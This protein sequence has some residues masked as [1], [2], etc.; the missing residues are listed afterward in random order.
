MRENAKKFFTATYDFAV[1]LSK[2]DLF[3][4]VASGSA[5]AYYI[6]TGTLPYLGNIAAF[7]LGSLSG[8]VVGLGSVYCADKDALNLS[9]ELKQQLNST[10]QRYEEKKEVYSSLKGKK[11]AL[12]LQQINNN[13]QDKLVGLFQLALERQLEEKNMQKVDFAQVGRR[14][15]SAEFS[16]S[17]SCWTGTIRPREPEEKLPSVLGLLEDKASNA[18]EKS[19]FRRQMIKF[20]KDASRYQYAAMLSNAAIVFYYVQFSLKLIVEYEIAVPIGVVLGVISGPVIV[21]LTSQSTVN[22]CQILQNKIQLADSHVNKIDNAISSLTDEVQQLENDSSFYSGIFSSLNQKAQERSDKDKG[23]ISPQSFLEEYQS[24][25]LFAEQ[26]QK[27]QAEAKGKEKNSVS[28]SQSRQS[29]ISPLQI[30][31]PENDLSLQQ[32]LLPQGGS[33]RGYSKC[34][35]L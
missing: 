30:I 2:S 28:T 29:G 27:K 35:I 24:C 11:D 12:D 5:T 16:S 10:L 8:G 21:R 14:K 15:S 6:G 7:I 23:G 25:R 34:L 9:I 22:E 1:N 18:D 13:R 31:S 4:V 19:S 32:P 20:F 26:K 33:E 17:S 3:V